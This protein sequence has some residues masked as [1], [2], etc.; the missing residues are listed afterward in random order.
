MGSHFGDLINPIWNT[1]D[2]LVNSTFPATP[3][4]PHS[5][6]AQWRPWPGEPNELYSYYYCGVHNSINST[7]LKSTKNGNFEKWKMIVSIVSV[8]CSNPV[9]GKWYFFR[10]S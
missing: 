10:N 9:N 4:P 3:A 6:T 8:A 1:S 5:S 2:I 7:N